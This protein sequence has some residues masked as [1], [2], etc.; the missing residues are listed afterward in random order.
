MQITRRFTREG[1]DPFAG[2]TFAPRTSVIRNPNGSVVFEMKDVMVPAGWSQVAVD[3]LAQKYFRRAGVPAKTVRVAEDGIPG[4]LQRNKPEAADTALAGETDSRQV[5]H[6]LAGCWTYWG[7]KGGYFSGE[8]AA[9]AFY[10]EVCYMLAAQMAAPNSPQWFNTGLHWAYGIEG[11]AQGHSFVNPLTNEVTRSTSAYERPAPHACFI[12]QVSDDL[13]NEGGIMDLWV[14]EARIFKYGSGTGSNFSALRGEGEPLSGGG[15]SSGLMSFL[16]IGDRAAGAI[17]SGG[18]T[19]RAAKMVV[20]DLDHPDIEEFVNWKVTEE[21]KVADLVT[22]SRLMNK[23]LNAVL[24]AIHTHPNAGEKFDPAKNAGLRKAVLEA[25][26][27]LIPENYIARVIQLAKQGFTHLDVE[28]YDTDWNSKAYYTVSGQ[29]SN[30]SVRITN[31]FMKAVEADGPWQLYWR[32]ELEKAAKE[33]RDPK[34]KRT[35]KARDLWDQI[36]FAAWSCADPG[37]Q[38]DGTFNEWHTCPA[39][40]RINATNPCCVT[41][42]T[43]VAVADGRNAV[44]IKDLVGREV[45]VYAWDHAAKRTV[46]GRMWNIGV[47]RQDARVFKVT[48]DDGSSF[49]ATDDHLIMLRDGAYRQVKDLQPGDSLNP[50]H[51]KVRRPKKVRTKRRFVHTGRG[52]RVQYR[53]VWEAAFGTQPD[54]HHIHHRDFNSLNDRLDNLQLLPEEDHEALHRDQMLGDNNPARRFMNDEWRTRISEATRGERN[55]HYGKPQTPEARAKMR[56]ASA[57]RWADPAEH[58]KAADAAKR[59]VD[60]ARAAG[61]R[62]GRPAKQRVQRCCAVCR[63]NFL[64]AREGQLF[65]SKACR[66]SPTALAMVGA[67]GGMKKRGRHLTAE[68]REKLRAASTAAAVPA[69]KRRAAIDSLRARCLK[70]ARL[71]LDAGHAPTLDGWDHLRDTAHQ[72]GAAHFPKRESVTRFFASDAALQENAALYNHKVVSVEFAGVEDVYDGTVDIHHNFAIVTS[73]TPSGVA[74]GDFDYSGCFI[75]NSEYAFLD[76]TACNLASLN[77]LTFHDAKAGKFDT[78]AYR[79]AVRV[80]TLILEIS[81][82]MA[83]FPSQS[84]ARK[85]YDFRTLGLGYANLGALLMVQ[86]IPYDSVEARA[87]CGALTA[88]MH[89]GAYAASAEIAAEVGPFARYEA[90]REAMLRVVRNHRRA[91]YNAAPAEYEELTVFPVGIDARYCPPDLLAAARFESDRMLELGE[92]YGYRNA[93]VTVIAPTGTIGL[94]MDCDTTGIEPDFALVKFKKLAG[95]GYF[96]IINQS[97]PPA[98]AKLGYAPWQVDDIVRH[99]KGAATLAGCPHINPGSLKAKGF[100]DEVLLKVEEQLPGAFELPFV[101][102]RWTLGEAFLKDILKI[103]EATLNSPTF[104]LLAHL[105]FTRQQITEASTFVCGTMT[106]EGAPHLKPEHYPVFDCANKCGKTG[107]RFL[108]WEAHI[109][110]MAAAQPFISGA[111]SKTINMPHDATVED[112]KKAYWLSWQ[113]MTKANALYRDGSKLSQPLN[114]VADS[115]EAA[116]LASVTAEPEAEVKPAAVQVAERI[117]EKIVHRYIARRRRLPDRRSGYTQKARIGNHKMY[118]RTGEYEDGTLGEI[119]IDMHK[120]GAAFRSMTN[121][122]AIAVSLGMQHGVPLEEYVDAFL[123]TRFEPNGV[124]QG[125]PYIKMSTSII[126]YIFRELAITYLDRKDLAHVL[127]EDL[128]GDSLHDEEDDPDFDAEEVISERT[129]DAKTAGKPKSLAPPRSTHLKPGSGTVPAPQP[130]NGNG[131]GN[132]HG[133]TNGN[134]ATA[135]KPAAAGATAA[136]A[137][138][139]T[140]VPGTKEER[141]RIAKQKG[142]EGDPCSNCQQLTLVRSGACCKC[143]TCGETSGCS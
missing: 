45:P 24:R 44:P 94:V 59:G 106:I 79:H 17:K 84:V 133:K 15:K 1:Q 74:P 102:N 103:P 49:R 143:D 126:D 40:G 86:G 11:P 118:I 82:Y 109:R 31:G 14:R 119:F 125:N 120:E 21:Q 28:E 115:D 29:N 90:N 27:A 48:L 85:S 108:A 70:A 138:V 111:I 18:T 20:L 66:Y 72:L 101:F 81:V 130:G 42:D 76:D 57:K 36:A 89:A 127:P 87:Q 53:W 30:N 139:T 80:W 32:T 51:S 88:I 73:Q 134:G 41:G 91:A 123:F 96:K 100:T 65:C 12:Q 83:Q 39:D 93:Q 5:F 69:D 128:R 64:T 33:N 113:L 78:E 47:K 34:P 13:V 67:K 58:A 52:W 135:V 63:T 26:S 6:R 117:T 71:L 61:H 99:C 116:I 54:G 75:H 95:G 9:R 60:S 92:K 114:S 77:L 107:K 8:R 136:P 141:I 62:I 35:L 2:L 142:Y 43:L 46:I 68:H 55:P 97:V 121:C 50:F 22:G 38:F 122:F 19:R 37:V 7:W 124:V 129:V 3:I 105:G 112:V 56:T 110:M 25:R 131:N 10:D 23:H 140:P 16:K 132:G 104:D 98:L 4:W 137:R